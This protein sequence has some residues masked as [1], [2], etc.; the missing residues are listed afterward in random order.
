MGSK[1]PAPAALLNLSGGTVCPPSARTEGAGPGPSDHRMW[2]E[3]APWCTRQQRALTTTACWAVSSKR[4]LTLHGG[5]L[6]LSDKYGLGRSTPRS[7]RQTRAG[8]PW[9]TRATPGPLGQPWAAGGLAGGRAN[10]VAMTVPSRLFY[11]RQ[12][13][14][15][16]QLGTS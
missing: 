1:V 5:W 13:L 2:P 7:Y 9:V 16:A 11:G 12:G 8:A 14:T 3:R 4:E 10:V 6:V 15:V